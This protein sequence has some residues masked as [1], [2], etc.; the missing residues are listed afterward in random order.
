VYTVAY[1]PRL[2]PG[3]AVLVA[4]ACD[5]ILM[6]GE[7]QF[8]PVGAA[9]EEVSDTERTAYAEIADRRRRIPAEVALW[10]LDPSRDVLKVQTDLPGE[11]YLVPEDLEELRKERTIVSAQPLRDWVEGPPGQFTG[12]EASRLAIVSYKPASRKDVAKLLDLAPEDVMQDP[13]L[14]RRWQ[15]IQVNLEGRIRPGMVT[16]AIRLIK[17]Q[18]RSGEKNFVCLYIDSPGGSLSD[19]LRLAGFL[20]HDLQSDRVRTVAYVYQQARSDAALIAL[21]CDQVVMHPE[22][23]LGGQSEFMPSREDAAEVRE[24][25]RD[26]SGPW[27]LRPWPLV[28]AMI[29]PNLAVFP[30]RQT[31]EVDGRVSYLSRDEIEQRLAENKRLGTDKWTIGGEITRPGEPLSVGARQAIE[32]RLANL[33]ADGLDEFSQHYDLEQ[34]TLLE[35]GW[36]DLLIE[37]LKTPGV[38]AFLLLVAFVALYFELH[39]PGLGIGGFVAGLSFLLFFWIK[40]DGET[41]TL[42]EVMLFLAG[43]ACLLLEIFVLPGFGIFGLGG[44]C[45]VLISLI[46]ASQTYMLPQ[47]VAELQR[48][49]TPV[50][51]AMLGVMA[52]VFL[53]QRWLPRA[54]IL[55]E[56]LLEPPAGE[57][58]E[59]ISRRESLVD[60]EGFVG[61]R[62]TATT[63]LTPGGKAR[64]GEMLVDVI[65]DGEV[66]SRGTRIEVVEVRGNHLVVRAVERS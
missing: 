13:S 65:T 42:L 58:A 19:S 49:L 26:D 28:A 8:G 32:Y 37:I 15:A 25:I 20:A 53:L 34:L 43:V 36:T 39:T 14:V 10:L 61:S 27:R 38:D 63:Q 40:F 24:A 47:N 50:V 9:S 7:A 22:A 64:F 56:M 3:H 52:A 29:D 6:P 21:A 33:T 57:E 1:V 30:C 54:P 46:L 51:V 11:M 31:G 18:T 48:S 23:E 41:L 17:E 62:G 16:Q 2:L 4:M 12:D 44:G 55:R 66:V 60:L 59:E 5:D 35:P 45:L